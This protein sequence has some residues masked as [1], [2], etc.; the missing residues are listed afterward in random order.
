MG[1]LNV[2]GEMRPLANDQKWEFAV[3]TNRATQ[4]AVN[5]GL[6]PDTYASVV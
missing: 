3:G 5:R 1:S 4:R 6:G 2:N